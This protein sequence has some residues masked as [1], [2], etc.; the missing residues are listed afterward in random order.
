MAGGFTLWD[1]TNPTAPNVWFLQDPVVPFPGA[2]SR[3]TSSPGAM[4]VFRADP[5]RRVL[6]ISGRVASVTGAHK[7]YHSTFVIR[8]SALIGLALGEK[9]GGT[10]EW[11]K[12]GREGVTIDHSPSRIS[13]NVLVEGSRVFIQ[14]TLKGE[15]GFT[16][17]DFTPGARKEQS[18]RPYTSRRIMLIETPTVW[19][20]QQT[21]EV[22]GDAVVLFE[23]R[24]LS[25]FFYT[26]ALCSNRLQGYPGPPATLGPSCAIVWF[27]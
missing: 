22:S 25:F 17:Y 20:P 1:T 8:S 6:A 23:V 21:W 19:W 18:G 9:G 14:E 26:T 4:G 13:V 24:D 16:V 2:L 12:W 15:V 7:R 5:S 11:E 10:I 3:I 27:A